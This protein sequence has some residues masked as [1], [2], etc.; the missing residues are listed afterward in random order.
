MLIRPI[1]IR[2]GQADRAGV[3]WKVVNVI[4]NE[5][6]RTPGSDCGRVSA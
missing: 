2:M 1:V 3:Y 6:S 5:T 4:L